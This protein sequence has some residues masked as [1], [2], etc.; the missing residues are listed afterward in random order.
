MSLS[1][2]KV[3]TTEYP[4]HSDTE[5]IDSEVDGINNVRESE[6][7]MDPS[8]KKTK[9]PLPSKSSPAVP[10]LHPCTFHKFR[11]LV[12]RPLRGAVMS[13][14]GDADCAFTRRE[15][16]G[17]HV[18]RSKLHKHRIALWIKTGIQPLHGL[19]FHLNLTHIHF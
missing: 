3:L 6:S 8:D 18:H 4:D 16:N 2:L 7:N 13:E 15:R 11:K 10:L 14:Q 17:V 5:S 12:K 19:C 1:W 9:R